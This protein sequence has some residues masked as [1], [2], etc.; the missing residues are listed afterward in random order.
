VYR[1]AVLVSGSGTNL[2]ALIDATAR[3]RL[4]CRIVKVISD[5]SGAYAI[6][7]ARRAG[8]P[9]EV[10]SRRLYGDALSDSI[11]A[12]LPPGVDIIVLAGFLSILRGC[13]LDRFDGRILNIHPALLPDFG[14]RG[15]Y[16]IRVHRAVLN[17]GKSESGCSVHLVDHGTDTGPVLLQTRVPV[18]ENDTPETLAD[19]VRS[20]EH[21]TLI[22]GVASLASRLGLTL[23]PE[24]QP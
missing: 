22:R 2:Q 13:I 11:L 10:V 17:A 24:E 12:A 19:R 7:R 8:I 5:R 21:E 16:G 20:V 9:A 15:M 23:S 14:G 6:E 1:V 4:D 3:G 18:E